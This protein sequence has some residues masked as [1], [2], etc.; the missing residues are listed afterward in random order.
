MVISRAKLYSISPWQYKNQL[1]RWNIRKN[2][3]RKEWQQYFAAND[4]RSRATSANGTA[5][6]VIEQTNREQEASELMGVGELSNFPLNTTQQRITF[7]PQV[8]GK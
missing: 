2:A 6:P 8:G 4:D 1:K 7:A 5:T 3:T